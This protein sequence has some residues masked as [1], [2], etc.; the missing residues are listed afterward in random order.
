MNPVVPERSKEERINPY[1]EPQKHKF[2]Q[3]AGR[4]VRPMD[5]VISMWNTTRDKVDFLL[6]ANSFHPMIKF[7]VEISET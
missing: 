6:K 2:I 1:I 4:D 5:D 3:V 7:T